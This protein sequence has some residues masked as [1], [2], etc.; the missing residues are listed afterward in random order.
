ME[1]PQDPGFWLQVAQFLASTFGPGGFVLSLVAAAEGYA[2]W[3]LVTYF[4]GRDDQK[5]AD[6]LSIVNTTTAAVKELQQSVHQLKIVVAAQ[7]GR[8]DV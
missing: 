6:V 8:S 5:R 1:A 4:A 3:K 2:L 7:T